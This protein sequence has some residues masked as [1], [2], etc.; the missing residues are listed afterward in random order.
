MTTST[1]L[2]NFSFVVAEDVLPVATP[3][4]STIGTDRM[5]DL[6]ARNEKYDSF[7]RDIIV[8]PTAIQLRPEGGFSI[9][10]EG[11]FT[12]EDHALRQAGQRLGLP[13]FDGALSGKDTKAYIERFPQHY[14]PIWQSLSEG[15]EATGNGS[16]QVLARTYGDNAIRA[17]MSDRF[18]AIDN[19]DMLGILKDYLDSAQDGQYQ[20]VRPWIS[21]DGM[22]VDVIFPN[23]GGGYS[24]RPNNTNGDDSGYGFGVRIRTGEIGNYS[25]SVAPLLQ[26]HA[27]TNSV[28]STDKGITLKQQGNREVKMNLL[29]SAIGET[30]QS[31]VELVKRLIAAR[32]VKLPKMASIISEMVRKEEWSEEVQLRFS[33]GTENQDSLWGI[34]NGLTYAAHASEIGAEQATAMEE[35]AGALLFN[36]ALLNKYVLVER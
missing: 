27:C 15:Y 29:I 35:F 3:T 31:G 25:P 20:L 33:A 7:K 12:L 34:V 11:G 32:N 28:V 23:D 21:R 26:R 10:G 4:R 9:N 2:K 19:R 14:G 1:L 24:F 18:T 22:T 6:I 8:A 5:S 36:P 16:R 13:F 30:L 17:Y